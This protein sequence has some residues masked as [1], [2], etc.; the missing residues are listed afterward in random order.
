MITVTGNVCIPLFPQEFEAKTE[1][2]PLEALPFVE[3]VIEFEFDPD[4]IIQ[5]DGKLQV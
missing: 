5:P 2:D 4:V 3:T 1:I